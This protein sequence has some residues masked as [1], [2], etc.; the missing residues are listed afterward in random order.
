MQFCLSFPHFLILL[1]LSGRKIFCR[2]I[3]LD[4]HF[5]IHTLWHESNAFI[6]RW[7]A[8]VAM[9]ISG[10][11]VTLQ[12]LTIPALVIAPATCQVVSCVKPDDCVAMLNLDQNILVKYWSLFLPPFFSMHAYV[13]RCP[14]SIGESSKQMNEGDSELWQLA[15]AGTP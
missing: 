1:S 10:P 4:F 14:Q 12:S 7:R 3:K 2:A 8:S 15:R 11:P 6:F 13:L 9:L 5:V